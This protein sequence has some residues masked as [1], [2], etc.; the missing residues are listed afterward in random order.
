[1]TSLTRSGGRPVGLGGQR[2][3]LK[4]GR[5]RVWGL[6]KRVKGGEAK[7]VDLVNSGLSQYWVFHHFTFL[8]FTF[9]GIYQR[10]SWKATYSNSYIHTLMVMAAMQ[11]VS[12]TSGAV[13]GSVSCP[14]TPQH[15]DQGK[16]TSNRPITRNLLLYPWATAGTMEHEEGFMWNWEQGNTVKTLKAKGRSVDTWVLFSWL[17]FDLTCS[18]L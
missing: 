2:A 10:L 9:Q 5:K 13:W 17:H 3:P 15:A 12:S 18:S 7:G 6:G 1:M 11:C 8:T 16:R 14:R 4:T